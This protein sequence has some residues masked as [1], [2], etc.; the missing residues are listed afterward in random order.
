MGSMSP[1]ERPLRTGPTVPSIV[2]EAD[3]APGEVIGRYIVVGVLGRGGMGTVY[4]AYDTQLNRTLAIKILH[5]DLSQSEGAEELAL[6]MQREAQAMARLRHPN[7]VV[8]HDVGT[9]QERVF[10][11]MEFVDGGTLKEWLRENPP[12]DERLRVLLAAGRGLAAAH[13]AGLIHRDFKPDNVLVGKDGRVLVTDFGIARIADEGNRPPDDSS[14]P[15]A[16]TLPPDLLDADPPSSTLPPPTPPVVS[17]SS[18]APTMVTLSATLTL[19]GSILGT[20]GFMAPEQAFGRPTTAASDQF[21]FCVTAYLTLYGRN[22]FTFAGVSEYFTAL[23]RPLP[24]P[25]S[26]SD[27]PPWIHRILVR[28]LSREPEDR[29]PSMDALLVALEA[30]PRLRSHPRRTLAAAALAIGLT[31]AGVGFAMHTR[32]DECAPDPMDLRGVWDDAARSELTAAFVRNGAPDGHDVATRVIHVMDETAAKW[33]AMKAES[34]EATRIKKRQP[35]DAYKLRSECLDRRRGE[36]RALSTS[37]R[38]ADEEVVEK[39]VAAAYGLTNVIVCGDVSTLR[40]SGGLPDAPDARAKVIEARADLASATSFELVGKLAE[41]ADE[42]ERALALAR[43]AGHQSTVAEA[44]RTLGGLKVEQNEHGQAERLLAEATWTASKAGDDPLVVTTASALAFVVGSKLGRPGEARI[45]LGVA[46]AALGRVGGSQELELEYEEH[47]A[48]LLSDADGRAE[49][50]LASQERIAQA[51]QQ[52]YGVHPRTLRALYNLGDGLTSAGDHGRACDVYAR[53]VVMG[54]AVGGPNYSWTG[55]ALAGR[56][57]CLTAQGNF[58]EGDRA[59]DRAVKIAQ[60]TGDDYSEVEALEVVIRSALEQ[61]DDDRAL[62]AAR[63]ARTLMKTLEGTAS[64]AAVANIPIAEALMRAPPAPEAE[65]ICAEALRQQELLGQIDPQK[66]LRADA[67]RC[68]GD[69]LMQRGRP[70]EAVAALERTLTIPHRAYPGDLAR[71]RFALARALVLSGGDVARAVALARQ[72]QD[73]FAATPGL[74]IEANA[75]RK[76][77]AT[78]P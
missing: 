36:L 35:E 34:C 22:P 28:G 67:L 29:F 44:L 51:Y 74:T 38:V 13:A 75:T 9:F 65:S 17:L 72:A 4:R 10:L 71:A 64:L 40:K 3:L 61:G 50:T 32:T 39:A 33:M 5:G 59:L 37:F 8:V 31:V 30:D 66:T 70:R 19:P 46:D 43:S 53:A 15:N 54:E 55:Y 56:G 25:P 52:L 14:E 6:R 42:G 2:R 73:D 7:V 24:P 78:L 69:A 23:D 11:A 58:A 12:R 18:A 26:G 16:S 45:W 57:D 27:V 77:L 49:E 60:A 68:L 76:W 1:S 63:R 20:I 41:S 47:K 48:W 62:K 21:S